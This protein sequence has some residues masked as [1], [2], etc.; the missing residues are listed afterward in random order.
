MGEGVVADLVA[1]GEDALDQ[2]RMG[3]GVG[4]D[5]EETR[6]DVLFLQDIENRRRPLRVRPVVECQRQRMGH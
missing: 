3:L 4:A 1:F 2:P 5:D 6:L